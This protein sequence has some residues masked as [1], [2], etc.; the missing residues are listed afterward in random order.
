MIEFGRAGCVLA[1]LGGGI[2]LCRAAWGKVSRRPEWHIYCLKQWG[3]MEYARKYKGKIKNAGSLTC[4][5]PMAGKMREALIARCTLGCP[6][7]AAAYNT[8]MLVAARYSMTVSAV[9]IVARGITGRW[10][11]H[12]L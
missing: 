8:R 11:G 4:I 10:L 2:S 7:T 12:T 1:G 5:E 9:P 6:V 3:L